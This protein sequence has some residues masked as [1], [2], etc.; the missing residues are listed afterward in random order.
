MRGVC[1]S[2]RRGTAV[3]LLGNQ[4][5]FASCLTSLVQKLAL[6]RA[7]QL[8]GGLI[9]LPE[10]SLWKSRTFKTIVQ[11]LSLDLESHS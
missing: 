4:G 11:I 6:N 7:K 2:A 3:P 10:N 8:R 5:T 1:G 9:A